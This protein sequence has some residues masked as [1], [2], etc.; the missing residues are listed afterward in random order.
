[1]LSLT[2]GG[3]ERVNAPEPQNSSENPCCLQC[4]FKI[5][6]LLSWA[7]PWDWAISTVTVD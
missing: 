2:D 3:G 1:M 5:I 6:F 7:S 4:V